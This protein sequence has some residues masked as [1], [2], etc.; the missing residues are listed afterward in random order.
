M[1][2][3]RQ[4][5]EGYAG[6]VEQQRR[7]MDYEGASNRAIDK[8]RSEE[9]IN[10]GL[11]SLLDVTTE[12]KYPQK[13]YKIWNSI[14]SRNLHPKATQC[15]I[16]LRNDTRSLWGEHVRLP[17]NNITFGES[18]DAVKDNHGLDDNDLFH[19]YTE[20]SAAKKYGY[21]VD[22]NKHKI[23]DKI[24]QILKHPNVG[25]M[26]KAAYVTSKLLGEE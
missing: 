21:T 17:H 4:I 11:N 13:D 18:F 3:F 20:L 8:I 14:E 22:I 7:S 6:E 12:S 26:T 16:S 15:I 24:S 5:V 9:K 23:D 25:P 2:T 19:L 1:S 10:A